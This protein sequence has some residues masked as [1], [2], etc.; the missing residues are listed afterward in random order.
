MISNM[1]EYKPPKEIADI[2]EAVSRRDPDISVVEAVAKI[3]A[4]RYFCTGTAQSQAVH[5][6]VAG[7]RYTDKNLGHEVYVEEPDIPVL[8]ATWSGKLAVTTAVFG[9][10]NTPR[11]REKLGVPIT[12]EPHSYGW[13]GLWYDEL[14]QR[15]KLEY[16]DLWYDDDVIGVQAEPELLAAVQRKHDAITGSID[17]FRENESF[18]VHYG[19]PDPGQ[20]CTPTRPG[21]VLTRQAQTT[22]ATLPVWGS[23][24]WE[25][26]IISTT[27]Y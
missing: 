23:D 2:V 13:F 15:L 14:R 24:L 19:S 17:I 1:S 9:D 16:G 26:G 7:Q 4:M 5:E 12:P 11:Q 6:P 10:I 18:Y 21:I 22:V 8:Q 27:D 3:Q 25:T 20:L